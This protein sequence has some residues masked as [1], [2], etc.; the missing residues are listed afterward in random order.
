MA[1]R[2]PVGA[3]RNIKSPSFTSFGSSPGSNDVPLA[4]LDRLNDQNQTAC[5][6]PVSNGSN[7]HSLPN[8]TVNGGNRSVQSKQGHTEAT[9]RNGSRTKEGES[10]NDNEWVE[11]DEPGVYIT[12]TSLPGGAK[13]LKRVRFRFVVFGQHS[14][15]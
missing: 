8:G 15:K 2:L 7:N 9:T 3:A 4:T 1:E 14:L 11:Q 6:E 13:D 10:R 5:Q 12:L